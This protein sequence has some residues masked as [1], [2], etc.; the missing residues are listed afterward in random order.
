MCGLENIR[1]GLTIHIQYKIVTTDPLG[2]M[3]NRREGTKE[4]PWGV[5]K[6]NYTSIIVTSLSLIPVLVIL[7]ILLP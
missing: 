5:T 1:S 7:D 3:L 4:I 6:S 2:G